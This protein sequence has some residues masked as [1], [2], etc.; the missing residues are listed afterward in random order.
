METLETLPNALEGLMY[1]LGITD[2]NIFEV[3]LTEEKVYLKGL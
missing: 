2:P 3:W 1:E